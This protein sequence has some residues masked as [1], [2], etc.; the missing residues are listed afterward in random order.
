MTMTED[1]WDNI[2]PPS[3]AEMINAHRV[4]AKLPWKFY[5]ARGVD[6]RCMLILGHEEA[7]FPKNRLPVL[8]GV[9]V[10]VT[11]ADEQGQRMLS[12]KLHDAGQ[13]D[14]F[15]QLCLDIVNC[16]SKGDTEKEVVEL[17]LA[18]TWRWHHLLRGGTNQLLSPEE[19]KGLIG[20]LA[21]LEQLLLPKLSAFDAINAW[22]GPLGAPKDFEIGRVC[23]EAKARRG[24][25][26]P[27]VVISSEHQ[28][29]RLGTDA[30]FLHVV[31][32]AV[33]NDLSE[34]SFTIIDIANRLHGEIELLDPGAASQFEA[35]LASAGLRREDDYSE[36][37]WVRG[38]DRLYRVANDFPAITPA[39]YPSG[40][41]RVKYEISLPDCEPF[42]VTEEQFWTTLEMQT[43]V[44]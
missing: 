22:S 23:I 14:I 33:A 43:D 13:R 2:E 40:I 39:S 20:E 24:T 17:T 6:K 42:L 9:D 35:L 15:H 25:S 29:D 19:Q 8:K 11:D 21:V 4:D 27:R 5:W 26:K 32:L 12:L 10:N 28:L 31:E 36:H 41:S 44:N 16:A 34:S 38:P 1:P 18:R 30:F 7:S 3:S 37:I